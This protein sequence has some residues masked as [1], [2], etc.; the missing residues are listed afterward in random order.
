MTAILRYTQRLITLTAILFICGTGILRADIP[1]EQIQLSVDRDSYVSGDSIRFEARLLDGLGKPQNNLSKYIYVELIDPFGKVHNRVKIKEDNGLFTGYIPL[2]RELAESTYTL[3]AYTM[4]MRNR[5]AERFLKIP[6]DIRSLYSYKYKIEPEFNAGHL[7]VRLSEAAT[8]APVKSESLILYGPGGII[9]DAGRK[10]SAYRFTVP[11]NIATVMVEFDNFRKF[12]ALPSDTSDVRP[13]FFPEG[14][15]LVPETSNSLAIKTEDVDGRPISVSGT[16]ANKAGVE[17][18]R[19]R[20]D[21][22]GLTRTYFYPVEGETYAALICGKKFPLPQVDS[23]AVALQVVEREKQFILD[24]NGSRPASCTLEANVG[25]IT[26]LLD[27]NPEFPMAIDCK[28]FQP[29]VI[30]FTILDSDGE[31]LSSRSVFNGPSD[32][33]RIAKDTEMLTR[34]PENR[35]INAYPV[36]IGGEISGTIKSRWRGTPLKNADINLLAPSIGLAITSRTDENGRFKANGFDWPDGTTFIIQA[37]N[38]KGKREHNFT[39]DTDTFPQIR[40]LPLPTRLNHYERP[41]GDPMERAGIM[42]REIEVTARYSPE[43]TLEK[44]YESLGART[45]DNNHLRQRAITSYEEAIRSIPS[46]RIR[47]GHVV[48]TRGATSINGS[49]PIV[50]FCIGGIQWSAREQESNP[51]I[52]N[53]VHGERISNPGAVLTTSDGSRPTEGKGQVNISVSS[54]Q[55]P[56]I[57]EFASVY[58]FHMVESITYIPPTL[59]LAYS[60]SA[61]HGGG[62]LIV[63]LKSGKAAEPEDDIFM[64]LYTPLG[65][66]SAPAKSTL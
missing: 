22:T 52:P 48:S 16:I 44:M 59:A 5:G 7:T 53:P 11:K 38:A 12:I 35:S 27:P 28:S 45:I 18:T 23:R 46:L 65:Y 25:G 26:R 29:G 19:F 8:G 55:I 17:I 15:A 54:I 63:T 60:S 2:D 34:A 64:K 32:I 13:S 21:S 41:E 37:T 20:T 39:I 30:D 49:L 50:D 42:L 14:G 31:S 57:Q 4:F 1:Q 56:Q 10:K 47:N 62:L 43:K 51:A 61:A 6:V 3:A 66:Q 58:P 9:F 36:E 40:P 24:L 33:D